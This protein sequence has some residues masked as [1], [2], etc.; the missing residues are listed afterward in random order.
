MLYIVLKCGEV[1][2]MIWCL[3]CISYLIYFH[4]NLNNMSAEHHEVHRT[5]CEARRVS[6]TLQTLNTKLI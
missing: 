1:F 2:I 4:T 5:L 3:F 6:Q